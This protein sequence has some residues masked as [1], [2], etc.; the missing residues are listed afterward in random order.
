MLDFPVPVR[1]P[2]AYRYETRI[3]VWDGTAWYIDQGATYLQRTLTPGALARLV[4]R[5]PAEASV[6]STLVADLFGNLY[7]IADAPPYEPIQ[8]HLDG[9]LLTLDD[10]TGTV[11]DYVVNRV[12]SAVQ[13][14]EPVAQDS[15]IQIDVLISPT[16][17]TLGSVNGHT[18]LDFDRDWP[19]DPVDPPGGLQDGVNGSFPLFYRDAASLTL[20][21][22]PALPGKASQV[23]VY[24]D[25]VRQR[26]GT[27]YTVTGST[28]VMTTPPGVDALFWGLWYAPIVAGV[29]PRLTPAVLTKLVY[30]LPVGAT[31]VVT[32]TPDAF[33]V[34]YPL[35]GAAIAVRVYANGVLL[36]PDDGTGTLGDYVVNAG[37]NTVT[38]L[39]PLAQPAVIQLELLLESTYQQN[40]NET[41]VTA[42]ASPADGVFDF[43]ELGNTPALLERGG[44]LHLECRFASTVQGSANGLLT[45]HVAEHVELDGVPGAELDAYDRCLIVPPPVWNNAAVTDFTWTAALWI[46]PRNELRRYVVS[47]QLAQVHD[48]SVDAILTCWLVG[49]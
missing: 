23:E 5:L 16:G 38:L 9:L 33:N 18:L 11:G 40:L 34:T 27:D 3:W 15:I 30:P 35:V 25:G 22:R 2:Q 36:T 14:L 6:Q 46:P 29:Q 41:P 20:E 4:Y 8:V 19:S 12:T 28:L 24:V 48:A 21:P 1:V 44:T 13:L 7:A 10:G 17:G 47:A 42:T 39:A 26:P 45:V 49:E 43:G 32:T 37:V 31:E